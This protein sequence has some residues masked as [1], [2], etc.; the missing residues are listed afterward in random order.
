MFSV[1]WVNVTVP[2]VPMD[3]AGRYQFNLT[4]DGD[5]GMTTGRVTLTLDVGPVLHVEWWYRDDIVTSPDAREASLT[6]IYLNPR[7]GEVV[8]PLSGLGIANLGNAPTPVTVGVSTGSSELFLNLSSNVIE[9][10]YG[11]VVDIRTMLGWLPGLD[12]GEYDISMRLQIQGDP[13]FEVRTVRLHLVVFYQDLEIVNLTARGHGLEMS[14]YQPGEVEEWARMQVSF[15]VWNRRP[16]APLDVRVWVLDIAPDG[17]VAEVL[18]RTYTVV[19]GQLCNVPASWTA[20]GT[21]NHTLV[22]LAKAQGRPGSSEARD[23]IRIIVRERDPGGTTLGPSPRTVLAT[24]TCIGFL[25]FMML[26]VRELRAAS[27][28]RSK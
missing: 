24:I 10:P 19:P 16:D 7:T 23:G 5:G 2:A 26:L 18:N 27:A 21:G 13:H 12:P 8:N 25:V 1:A 17:S 20:R 22:A 14:S 4:A 6:D 28:R 15:D 9:V 3:Q 11:S